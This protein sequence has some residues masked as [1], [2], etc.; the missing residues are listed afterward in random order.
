MGCMLTIFGCGKKASET[1]A[2]SDADIHWLTSLDEAMVLAQ[3]QNKP[4]MIDFM[5]EWC[6]P[7][8]RMEKT[9]FN[10]PDVIEK[11]KSFV[12]LRIDVDEQAEIANKYNGNAE[13]YGGIGI[14][15]ILFMTHEEIRL[16]HI[17]GYQAPEALIAVMDSVLTMRD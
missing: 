17:I 7:C 10:Q 12:T 6:P 5:A 4:L 9:T 2:G 1:Q 15:N 11:T 16:K 13:K 3:E 14:P 8:Q